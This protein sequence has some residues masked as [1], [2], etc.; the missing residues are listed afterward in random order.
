[1]ERIA[2]IHFP[3]WPIQR[4]IGQRP[5]LRFQQVALFYQHPQRGQLVVAVSPRAALQGIRPGM[6]VSEAK[7][8]LRRATSG[9]SGTRFYLLPY[10]AGVDREALTAIARQLD[11]FS[12]LIGIDPQEPSASLLLDLT[13]LGKL[14][15][16]EATLLRGMREFLQGQGY[17]V[18]AAIAPTL[19]AAWA[20]AHYGLKEGDGR[21]AASPSIATDFDWRT[22]DP[23]PTTALRIEAGVCETLQQLGLT[24]IGALRQIPAASLTARFG[25]VIARRLHQLSGEQLETFQAVPRA[26]AYHAEQVL[27]FPCVIRRRCWSS[28]NVCWNAFVENC[29]AF[30][31]GL[32]RGTFACGVRRP[33]RCRCAWACF[34]LLRKS[35]KSYRS[36]ACNWNN[37]RNLMV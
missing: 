20:L 23:L 25:D 22:F 5:E 24:T 6:P 11:T 4:L 30:A 34:K 18:E 26:L 10:E 21:E 17:V 9:K 35:R 36:S 12:P 16:D 19:A 1:M 14:F 37:M 33:S 2:C 32:W 28:S 8:L 27:D 3:Q 31:K 15:G 13:G 7:S 29:N